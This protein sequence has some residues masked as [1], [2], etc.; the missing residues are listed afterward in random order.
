MWNNSSYQYM[1]NLEDGGS[2]MYMGFHGLFSL[3]IMGLLVFGVVLIVR[4]SSKNND[5]EPAHNALGTRYAKGE[6]DREEYLTKK[7]DIQD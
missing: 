5:H 3:V 4:N 1:T 6:I 2:L 7:N